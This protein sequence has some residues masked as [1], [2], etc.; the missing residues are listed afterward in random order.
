MPTY[1]YACTDCG[2]DL[3]V[4]QKFSDDALTDC[5]E[6]QGRLRK[7][8]S[9][10]GIVFKGSGFYRTDSGNKPNGSITGGSNS[11]E[12]GS[13]DSGSTSDST[14]S[15]SSNSSS[16]GSGDSGSSSGGSDSSASAASNT[17]VA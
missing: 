6:C 9:A 8:Y 10:V 17:K 13:S 11:S 3:E 4:V 7:V 5:P 14:A 1:Q 2:A 12:S 15:S 16:S